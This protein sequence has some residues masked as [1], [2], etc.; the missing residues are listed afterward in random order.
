MVHVCRLF[1]NFNILYLEIYV[2]DK[3]TAR[4]LICLL[5]VILISN[6]WVLVFTA[7]PVVA[8]VTPDNYYKNHSGW[9]TGN[10]VMR[11]LE[12]IVG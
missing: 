8:N 12:P 3:L 5:T 7:V 4:E 2:I 9:Y 6:I 1:F 11:F 10:D